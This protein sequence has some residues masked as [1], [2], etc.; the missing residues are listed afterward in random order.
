MSIFCR[1]LL[2]SL[3]TLCFHAAYAGLAIETKGLKEIQTP[4]VF[5]LKQLLDGSTSTYLGIELGSQERK[6]LLL[7]SASDFIFYR[8]S[9]SARAKIDFLEKCATQPNAFCEFELARLDKTLAKEPNQKA[10]A[11]QIEKWITAGD[12]KKLEDVSYTDLN[13]S[14]KKIGYASKL[15]KLA[16]SIEADDDCISPSVLNSLAAK[17]EEFFP[18]QIYIDEAKALYAKSAGC[19]SGDA[20]SLKAAYRLSILN[21]WQNQLE[22][23]QSLLAHVEAGLGDYQARAK[24]WRL[25]C[26][27][28]TSGKIGGGFDLK[29]ESL[30]NF[31]NILVH[32][33][34]VQA[35]ISADPDLKVMTRSV[36][37]PELN[38]QIEAIEALM[39]LHEYNLSAQFA[40]HTFR[41]LN[42]SEPEFRLY[43]AFLMHASKNSIAKFHILSSLFIDSPRMITESTLKMYFPLDFY[44]YAKS[45]SKEI[46]PF[47]I[48]SIIRQESAFNPKAQS[49]VGARGLMQI[50]SQ[51][52]KKIS[53]VS[54]TKLFDPA[55]NIKV[56]VK[57]FENQVDRFGGDIELALAAY[58]AGRLKVEDWQ[59]RYPAADK[60]LFLDLIPYRETREYVTMILRNYYWYQRLYSTNIKNAYK[61]PSLIQRVFDVNDKFKAAIIPID[62]PSHSE[63]KLELNNN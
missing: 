27:E 9:N 30:I 31:Q 47:I 50:M 2:P 63:T 48:L 4:Q 5:S 28:K 33:D 21:I 52:A 61:V 15:D 11:R 51:T 58:N 62:E 38:H 39:A 10:N 45:T 46:D 60:M 13:S 12:I 17:F 35:Q 7:Q 18:E 16:R 6:D 42:N 22:M 1:L 26:S 49:R 59:R 20:P 44:D 40:D 37:S 25:Y 43:L 36:I 29:N 14:M 32:G 53:S 24:Y 8:R 57:L 56:G 55:T 19:G 3:V 41:S 34:Q 54:R 23:A